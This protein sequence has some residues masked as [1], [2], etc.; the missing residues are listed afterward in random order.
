M[1]ILSMK[2][3]NLVPPSVHFQARPVNNEAEFGRRVRIEIAQLAEPC[4]WPRENDHM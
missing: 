1:A 4:K 2:I 3:R